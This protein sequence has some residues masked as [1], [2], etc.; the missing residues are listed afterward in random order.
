[1]SECFPSRLLYFGAQATSRSAK[2][3]KKSV[4]ERFWL[5]Q[6]EEA[7]RYL[8][9]AQEVFRVVKVVLT[10][11][12]T[13]EVLIDHFLSYRKLSTKQSKSEADWKPK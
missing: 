2:G 5:A 4:Q 9:H 10:T 7:R 11:P 8:S 6:T 3:L 13:R 12:P 1:M